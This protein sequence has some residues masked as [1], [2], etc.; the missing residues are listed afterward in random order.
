MSHKCQLA[1]WY[2]CPSHVRHLGSRI[3]NEAYATQNR[4]KRLLRK[5]CVEAL[6]FS[7]CE[8]L[9]CELKTQ[10]GNEAAG[11]TEAS[12]VSAQDFHQKSVGGLLESF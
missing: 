11:G 2:Y 1:D 9:H 3:Q 6:G 10:A 12:G 4:Q 5:G 8:D 7:D